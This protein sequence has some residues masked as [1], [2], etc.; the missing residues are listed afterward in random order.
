MKN[1]EELKKIR[2]RVKKDLELRAGKHRI[3]IIVC[4]GTCGIAAG[5]R[6]T[7]N[8]LVDLINSSGKTDII[9]TTSGCAGFCEQEPMIQVYIE[10]KEPVVYGKVDVKAA[11]EIF[12]KHILNGE[13]VEKY[14]FSKGK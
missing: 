13:I 6:Q 2:E 5:A 11:E 4:L 8:T 10:D 7:M 1:L 14:L 9:V 3:K 12:K